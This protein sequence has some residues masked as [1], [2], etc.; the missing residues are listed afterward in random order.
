MTRGKRIANEHPGD[1][2]PTAELIISIANSTALCVVQVV[3]TEKMVSRIMVERWTPG[4]GF[5]ATEDR[6]GRGQSH[7]VRGDLRAITTI[8]AEPN[9][10][11]SSKR[12]DRFG[13]PN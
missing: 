12:H 10:Q 5:Q 13:I 7:F 1:R 9:I 6:N 11:H 3:V 2:T 4:F 8:V